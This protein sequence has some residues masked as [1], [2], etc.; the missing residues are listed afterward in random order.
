MPKTTEENSFEEINSVTNNVTTNNNQA[1]VPDGECVDYDPCIEDDCK[2]DISPAT[3]KISDPCDPTFIPIY[4]TCAE[5][6]NAATVEV[7]REFQPRRNQCQSG[8]AGYSP[9]GLT[10]MLNISLAEG[11][12]SCYLTS[13]VEGREWELS[14]EDLAVMYIG[15][16]TGKCL[17]HYRVEIIP[18]GGRYSI[19]L[20]W[21]IIRTESTTL[22]YDVSTQREVAFSFFAEASVNHKQ[23]KMIK[24]DNQGTCLEGAV[25]Y[26]PMTDMEEFNY[27]SDV[28]S[29]VIYT[30]N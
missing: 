26:N 21:A 9:S 2:N 11:E 28:T 25:P 8:D 27:C 3:F 1:N 5:Q 17:K 10:V 12:L 18:L 6:L 19:V 16:D 20:P 24:I 22:T 15:N 23:A 13:L 14:Q 4:I 29:P 7:T 30:R